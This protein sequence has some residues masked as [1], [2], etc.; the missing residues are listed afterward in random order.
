MIVSSRIELS[1]NH[2]FIV[3]DLLS[4]SLLADMALKWRR[5]SINGLHVSNGSDE[6]GVRNHDSGNENSQHSCSDEKVQSVHIS[7]MEE[8]KLEI[9]EGG[10]RPSVVSQDEDRYQLPDT[11]NQERCQSRGSPTGVSAGPGT[12]NSLGSGSPN[13][14]A[15]HSTM[16][17][18]GMRPS[19]G[20]GQG[21]GVMQVPLHLRH[22]SLIGEP[23]LHVHEMSSTVSSPGK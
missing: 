17:P 2:L 8:S 9:D 5:D 19:P 16:G 13:L 12:T 11:Q 4:H 14:V 7:I 23:Q 6:N 22:E 18:L 1:L 20:G 21:G 3:I 15:A 10:N